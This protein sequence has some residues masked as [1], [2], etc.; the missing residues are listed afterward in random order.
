MR[1]HFLAV[2]V[3]ALMVALGSVAGTTRAQPIGSEPGGD[4]MAPGPASIGF[5]GMIERKNIY[6]II[7]N[8]RGVVGELAVQPG[9]AVSKDQPLLVISPLDPRFRKLTIHAP[10]DDG[11]VI[12]RHVENG[13]FVDVNDPLLEIASG[14]DYATVVVVPSYEV[15]YFKS[16]EPIEMSLYALGTESQLLPPPANIHIQPPRNGDSLYR[17]E[18]DIDCRRIACAKMDL[19]GALVKVRVNLSPPPDSRLSQQQGDGGG[20]SQGADK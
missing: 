8:M 15:K 9:S 14:H 17:V 13:H 10:V 18:M 19:A 4:R 5:V 11:I 3:L 20:G 1:S 7:S 2:S 16:G 12:A 6:D